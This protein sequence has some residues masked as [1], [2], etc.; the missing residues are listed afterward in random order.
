[1]TKKVSSP[2]DL[3]GEDAPGKARLKELAFQ[4]GWQKDKKVHIASVLDRARIF[5][6]RKIPTGIFLLDWYTHGGVPIGRVTRISGRRNSCKTTT[7]LR[8]LANAQKYCRYCKSPIVLTKDSRKDC[9]CPNP[10]Y[11]VTE[12]SC[13]QHISPQYIS[14]VMDGNLP[15]GADKKS[16]VWRHD[17]HVIKFEETYRCAPFRAVYIETEH[18][19]DEKWV[20]ANGVDLELVLVVGSDWAES[21]VDTAEKILYT[22]EFDIVFVDT[23]SMLVPR[24]TIEKS[25]EENSKIAVRATI[26]Q[27]FL[28]KIIASQYRYG[29]LDDSAITI[30]CATQVR[31]LGIGSWKGGHLGAADGN[32]MEHVV[33]LDLSFKEKGY[34]WENREYVSY[35]IFEF[36]VLKNHTGGSS[37]VTGLFNVWL[38]PKGPHSVGDTDDLLQ[39]IKYG[40]KLEVIVKAKE[41]YCFPNPYFAL[42]FPTLEEMA[43]E[44]KVKADLYAFL[45]R[46]VLDKL[47]ELRTPKKGLDEEKSTVSEV[48]SE[49]GVGAGGD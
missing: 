28:Q 4:L 48:C 31:T 37:A 18:K 35:G 22:G 38:D 21:T 42:V 44:L 5:Y 45:R 24:D 47:I 17:G 27:K 32:M 12:V 13:L 40:R 23:L 19:L 16:L 10:R 25:L 15:D 6:L 36:T 41:G 46:A 3:R 29:L 49:E 26:I 30:V 11:K 7:L 34:K 33:S 43:E 20:R 2:Y 8:I 9:L 39:T 14:A 1:V